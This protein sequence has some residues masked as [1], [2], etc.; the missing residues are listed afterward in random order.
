MRSRIVI[1]L[2]LLLVLTGCSL[3]EKR[4]ERIRSQYPQWD[5][6]TTEKVASRKVEPGM[7]REMVEV[8]LGKPETMTREGDEE[9]WTYVVPVTVNVGA[10]SKMPVYFV[11]FM[12]GKVVR[13]EGDWSKLGYWYY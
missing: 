11:F 10:I 13:T 6:A 2:F 9:K 4:M 1:T 7:T 5:L 3:K 12:D 8:A